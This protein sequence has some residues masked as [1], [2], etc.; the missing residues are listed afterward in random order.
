MEMSGQNRAPTSLP[1]LPIGWEDEWTPEPVWTSLPLP[2][3]E[4]RSSS[5]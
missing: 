1:P 2:E 3:I 5:P 4:P